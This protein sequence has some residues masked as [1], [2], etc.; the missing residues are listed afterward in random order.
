MTEAEYVTDSEG[1]KRC[2]LDSTISEQAIT[3]M[4]TQFLSIIYTHNKAANKIMPT[5]AELAI[6]ITHTTMFIRKP[7]PGTGNPGAS[8][9]RTG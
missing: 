9:R 6:L 1:G 7:D 3:N 5:V 4:Q 2:K 8:M